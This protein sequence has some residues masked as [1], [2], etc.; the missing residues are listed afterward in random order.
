MARF[1]STKFESPDR[2]VME[3]YFGPPGEPERVA[4][5]VVLTRR[6]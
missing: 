2:V 4:D 1:R 6:K 5:R 3:I